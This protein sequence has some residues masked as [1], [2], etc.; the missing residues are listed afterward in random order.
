[1]PNG[2]GLMPRSDTVLGN[3]ISAYGWRVD[4]VMNACLLKILKA[5]SRDPLYLALMHRLVLQVP[6][7]TLGD[8]LVD[9]PPLMSAMRGRRS[10]RA[11]GR[12]VR[13]SDPIDDTTV[14]PPVPTAPPATSGP[15]IAVDPDAPSGQ[16]APV[17]PPSLG[18]GM[19]T[20]VRGRPISEPG[21]SQDHFVEH[22]L[23]LRAGYMILRDVWTN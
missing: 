21:P 22:R 9:I 10:G 19:T 13:F 5:G 1:M 6:N 18:V 4:R 8:I 17:D 12:P 23:R 16:S 15:S 14:N 20:P 2:L 3:R 11:R 7:L